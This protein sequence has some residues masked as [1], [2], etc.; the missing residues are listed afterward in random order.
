[1]YKEMSGKDTRP[2]DNKKK[3]V[4][5]VDKNSRWKKQPNGSWVCAPLKTSQKT[6]D[7]Q[8]KYRDSKKVSKPRSKSPPKSKV[9]KPKSKSSPKSKVPRSPLDKTDWDNFSGLNALINSLPKPKPRAKSPPKPRAKSPPKPRARKPQPKPRAKSPPRARKP[10]PKPRAKSPQ[11]PKHLGERLSRLPPDLEQHIQI[12]ARREKSSLPPCK[13]QVFDKKS[14]HD[15]KSE[16]INNLI[17][18]YE[19]GYNTEYMSDKPVDYG[20]LL[21]EMFQETDRAEGKWDINREELFRIIDMIYSRP[22]VCKIH[23]V[24]RKEIW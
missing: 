19:E 16:A 5:C 20:G 18:G 12:L 3:I 7:A 11:P 13:R 1:M 17:D 23:K 2:R 10:P 6:R 14:A 24:L 15:A 8:K 4:P 9:S 22:S 21:S